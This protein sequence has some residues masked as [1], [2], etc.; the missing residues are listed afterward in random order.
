MTSP[1]SATN[2]QPLQQQQQEEEEE[3]EEEE[4]EGSA[5]RQERLAPLRLNEQ[6]CIHVP[7]FRLHFLMVSNTLFETQEVQPIGLLFITSTQ[8][9][10]QDRGHRI[11]PA[12]K[13]AS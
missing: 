10:D 13:S 1:L 4:A 9:Q 8:Q 6:P 7:P 12:T 11:C 5:G 3:E 2:S